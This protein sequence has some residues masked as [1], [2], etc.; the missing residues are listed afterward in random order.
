MV[1]ATLR[2]KFLRKKNGGK[3]HTV[4]RP[5]MI[6]LSQLHNMD[7]EIKQRM[8][9]EVFGMGVAQKSHFELLLDIANMLLIAGHTDDSR[10]YARDSADQVFLPVLTKI[11]TRYVLTAE[12]SG[13]PDELKTLHDMVEFS[14]QFWLRQPIT[15]YHRV[16]REL[17][18]Y[19]AEETKK[20][21]T[22]AQVKIFNEDGTIKHA[23]KVTAEI[24]ETA[25]E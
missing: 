2:S 4:A 16:A 20:R 22:A 19:H 15:L 24:E 23:D 25:N 10:A 7:L 1:H 14:R 6:V 9:V 3:S 11:H 12:L 17:E 13:S 18:A 21:A 8:A 5:P